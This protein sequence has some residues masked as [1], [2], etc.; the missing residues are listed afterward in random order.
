M[1]NISNN[2]KSTFIDE[3]MG[4]LNITDSVF[5]NLV[6]Q[7]V[8]DTLKY[9]SVGIAITKKDDQI[10]KNSHEN[11]IYVPRNVRK[12]EYKHT[13]LTWIPKLTVY[14]IKLENDT[15]VGG[16]MIL[17]NNAIVVIINEKFDKKVYSETVAH[18]LRH[19]YTEYIE[20]QFHPTAMI[21]D[22]RN[23]ALTISQIETLI[24]GLASN[25]NILNLLN[26]SSNS[27][28]T[29]NSNPNNTQEAFISILMNMYY[30][31][32]NEMMSYS[33]SF[34]SYIKE[35]SS[36]PFFINKIKEKS[37]RIHYVYIQY[38]DLYKMFNNI[39]KNIDTR[40]LGTMYNNCLG[41]LSKKLYSQQ[42]NRDTKDTDPTDLSIWIE[43]KIK[44]LK[45]WLHNAKSMIIWGID[46]SSHK[47]FDFKIC[48]DD[49]KFSIST[50]IKNIMNF[51]YILKAWDEKNEYEIW[52]DY[53]YNQV[54]ELLKN[55]Y[56]KYPL[57]NIFAKRL[58]ERGINNIKKLLKNMPVVIKEF[59][60]YV[61]RKRNA[62]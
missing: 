11:V 1:R 54:N 36:N 27:E 35:E 30:L 47:I 32:P 25:K 14:W 16:W 31:Q 8:D 53:K 50:D 5:S 17:N 40:I 20:K 44:Q 24:Y 9:P 10:I 28:M 13:N 29:I 23:K 61:E 7:I 26:L 12:F 52:I 21:P 45:K 19:I 56:K 18:E 43:Y 2:I 4:V 41:I 37:N 59:L 33:E 39:I 48:I 22:W 51:Y 62:N 42:H 3:S 57:A 49:K 46:F 15:Q 60:K 58:K 34:Y 6:Q 55:D 38:Y